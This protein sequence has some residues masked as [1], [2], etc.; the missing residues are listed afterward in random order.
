[1]PKWIVKKIL[2]EFRDKK[3]KIL[4]LG[5]AYKKNVD[6]DR[7]SP[8]FEIMKI[9]MKKK[10]YFDFN[11]PYF[12]SIRRGRQIA[13]TKKAILIN[14]KNLKFYDAVLVLTD[15]DKFDYKFIYN[16]SKKVFDC[17]GVYKR[18]NFKDI[19]YC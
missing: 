11:D 8:A 16:N 17:R 15:H 7:E 10:I 12:S 19:Y 5:I 14:K 2:N 1:M 4:I 13:F 3:P 18:F 6:D 9:L